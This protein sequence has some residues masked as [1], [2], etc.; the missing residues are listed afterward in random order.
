M[1]EA[2]LADPDPSPLRL[3]RRQAESFERD[4]FIHLPA[5]FS[6]QEV[7][8]IRALTDACEVAGSGVREDLDG[9]FFSM[10]GLTVDSAEFAGLACDGRLVGPAV[11]LLGPH[12]RFLGVQSIRREPLGGSPGARTP[13]RHGWHRDV[14]GMSRDLGAA[15]PRC[16]VKFGI[17][18]SDSLEARAGG[19]QFLPGS[20]NFP[21]LR[22]P[23]GRID[24][25]GA[26]APAAR[27]GDVV[28]FENRTYHAGGVNRSDEPFRLLL[29]QYGYRWLA[30]VIGRGHL[31]SLLS[32]CS[33]LNRQLLEPDECGVDGAYRPGSGA[34][35]IQDWALR[36]R[37]IARAR[38]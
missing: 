15:A 29:F 8:A 9:G 23:P 35:L 5:V 38:G 37:L 22:M 25:E 1:F 17:W 6:A 21:V 18:L 27:A 12:L 4:G 16:A 33:A 13:E 19:T 31:A 3:S 36:R 24:P 7:A 30:P 11:Q 14:Y 10:R 2:R 20:Q 26:V 34:R 32:A 28:I